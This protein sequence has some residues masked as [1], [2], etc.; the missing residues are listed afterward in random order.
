MAGKAY[1]QQRQPQKTQQQTTTKVNAR[2]WTTT[3][4]G[5]ERDG[6]DAENGEDSKKQHGDEGGDENGNYCVVSRKQTK[7]EGRQSFQR[8]EREDN[9]A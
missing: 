6:P 4:M 3:T 9:D 1:T 7:T 2:T 8:P 5:D